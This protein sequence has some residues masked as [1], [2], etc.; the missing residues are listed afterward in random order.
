MY[1]EKLATCDF[2]YFLKV[3]QNMGSISYNKRK[4]YNNILFYNEI[5][6][7]YYIFCK[8]INLNLFLLQINFFCIIPTNHWY[9]LIY[10]EISFITML[11][12]I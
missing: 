8:Y 6:K 3:K 9:K 4:Y 5:Y 11:S 10:L 2:K 1:V 7:I 12:Y